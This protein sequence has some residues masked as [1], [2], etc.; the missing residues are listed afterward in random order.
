MLAMYTGKA[1]ETGQEAVRTYW[2]PE[3]NLSNFIVV[4]YK[5]AAL[6]QVGEFMYLYV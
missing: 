2:C 4:M 3:Y 5:N 6:E 1:P